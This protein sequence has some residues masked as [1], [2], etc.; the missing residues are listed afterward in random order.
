MKRK[1]KEMW[2]RSEEDD[3]EG[4][5]AGFEERKDE[6]MWLGLGKRRL[7]GCGPGLERYVLGKVGQLG[8]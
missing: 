8:E 3:S 6:V 5:W 7:I 1:G 4:M 2:V